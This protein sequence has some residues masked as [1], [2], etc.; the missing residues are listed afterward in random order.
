MDELLSIPIYKELNVIQINLKDETHPSHKLEN[1]PLDTSVI[2]L[3]QYIFCKTDIPI[4]KQYLFFIS[5]LDTYFYDLIDD[6]FSMNTFLARDKV[7]EFLDKITNE[8]TDLE[9]TK[10]R[11]SREMLVEEITKKKNAYLFKTT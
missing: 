3:Q 10:T 5:P 6:L 7:L 9:F 8:N 2:E 11:I 4:Q 1:I